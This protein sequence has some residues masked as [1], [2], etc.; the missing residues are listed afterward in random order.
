MIF[1]LAGKEWNRG[2]EKNLGGV[3]N[4]NSSGF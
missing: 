4:T 1:N 2:K 3:I